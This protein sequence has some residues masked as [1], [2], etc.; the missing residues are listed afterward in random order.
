MV[1]LTGRLTFSEKKCNL[2]LDIDAINKLKLDIDAINK[3][4]NERYLKLVESV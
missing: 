3:L 1:V 2:K 4:G